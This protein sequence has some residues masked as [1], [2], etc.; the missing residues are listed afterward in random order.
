MDSKTQTMENQQAWSFTE[1]TIRLLSV[2][3]A[4][5]KGIL[6]DGGQSVS[7]LTD[8]FIG[9]SSMIYDL[10]EHHD[11]T[12]GEDEVFREKLKAAH[13]Q[14]SR[15]IVAFQFYDRIS[16]RL[17][18]VSLSLNDLAV[19]ISDKDQR[20]IAQPWEDL[21]AKIQSKYTME[22]ERVLFQQIMDG[23]TVDNALIAYNELA[24]KKEE[25]QNNEDDI[26]LF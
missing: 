16:Q 4:Q 24:S 11:Q 5:I 3:V 7:E 22:S 26:E 10:I 2:S 14:V 17:D 20:H 6:S 21:V 13:E 18:H 25:V 12:E 9:I 19:V 23:E 1:D 15:G 8:S